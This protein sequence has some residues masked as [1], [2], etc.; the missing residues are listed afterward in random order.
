MDVLFGV[1]KRREVYVKKRK[2]IIKM[3]REIR[4]LYLFFEVGIG[5]GDKGEIEFGGF[6]VGYVD[7]VWGLEER[8]EIVWI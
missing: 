5:G 2:R 1:R 7:V 4:L 6:G 8:I 3:L